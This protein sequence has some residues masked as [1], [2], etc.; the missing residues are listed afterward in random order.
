MNKRIYC[1]LQF[2]EFSDKKNQDSLN[3]SITHEMNLNA[4]ALEALKLHLLKEKPELL[5]E[6]D[7]KVTLPAPT[8][9]QVLAF[10]REIMYPIVACGGLIRKN[11]TY[12]VIKRL[13]TWDLPKGKLDEGETLMQCAIR[14]CEEECGISGL[15]IIRELPS[16]YHLYPYKK[17]YAVKQ[18]YWYEMTTQDNRTLVPQTEENIEAAV[19]MKKEEIETTFYSNTYPAIKDLLEQYFRQ[20]T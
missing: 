17:S 19:W 12:L 4:A 3:Q 1:S 8:F 20:Q 9:E 11:D 13:G 14:E 15:Q 5:S 16:T 2:L 7:H 10:L 6:K 18:T